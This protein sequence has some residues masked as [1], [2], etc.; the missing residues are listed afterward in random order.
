M[1]VKVLVR[2]RQ[3]TLIRALQKELDSGE[4][5]VL[6]GSLDTSAVDQVLD[7]YPDI[8]VVEP[9]P[10]VSERTDA[11]SIARKVC[12][13]LKVILV[14][15]RSLPD[16]AKIV[17]QGLFYYTVRPAVGEIVQIVHAAARAIRRETERDSGRALERQPP[18]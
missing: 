6:A 12:P 7:H 3:A 15:R 8:L 9:S 18:D 13:H 10:R 1:R 4:F 16:D 2:T 17:E 14:A 11:I 5:E